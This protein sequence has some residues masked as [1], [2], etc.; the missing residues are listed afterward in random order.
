MSIEFNY[1]ESG[2][3]EKGNPDIITISQYNPVLLRIYQNACKD[4]GIKPYGG[5]TINAQKK[6]LGYITSGYRDYK[7]K[8]GAEDSPHYYCIALDIY[9]DYNDLSQIYLFAKTCCNF[10]FTRIGFYPAKKILHIDMATPEWRKE[11]NAFFHWVQTKDLKYH[12]MQTLMSCINFIK[13]L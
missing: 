2:K 5:G 13:T 3:K 9:F 4:Y 10:G 11:R 8:D 7:P 1:R 12:G 6:G